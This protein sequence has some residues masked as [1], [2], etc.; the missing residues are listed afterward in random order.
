[1]ASPTALL[2]HGSSID[3]VDEPSTSSVIQAE[4]FT[5]SGNR[6][7]R[8]SKKY[9][10]SVARIQKRN[11]HAKLS[12]KGFILGVGIAIQEAGTEIVS[13]SNFA[14]TRHGCDPAV[15]AI[16]LDSVNDEFTIEEDLAISMEMTWW[17]YL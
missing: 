13:L 15:G 7:E 11:P 2:T 10:G 4:S 14:A 5:F 9:D 12:L 17:P 3:I 16:L 6:D 1:M 8:Q